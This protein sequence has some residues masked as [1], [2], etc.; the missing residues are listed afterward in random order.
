MADID[1]IIAGG[2]GASSRAD[3]SSIGGLADA[4]YKGRDEAAK[5]SQRD[6]FKD[7]VPTTPDGQPDFAAMGKAL[8]QTGAFDQGVQASNLDIARQGIQQNRE[9]AQFAATGQPGGAP[10]A[11]IVSPPSLNRSAPVAVAPALA[12][13]GNGPQQDGPPP[14]APQG[15]VGT[16]AQ[17]LAAQGIPNDQIG[18]A[19]A[20]IARQIGLSDP[21]AQINFQDPQIRNVVAPAIMQLKRM[22]LGQVQGQPPQGAP[23]QQPQQVA[24]QAPGVPQQQ[25]PQAQQPQAQPPQ[26]PQAPNP[27]ANAQAAGLI[28]P[29]V[30]PNR[31]VAGLKYRAAYL[32]KGPAQE[33]IQSQ[34]NAIDKASELTAT[35]RDFNASQA[36]PAIDERA[37]QQKADEAHA[38]GVAQSDIKEQDG[39]ISAGSMARQRLA[40]LNTISNIIDTDKNMTLG[41]GAE[42]ALKVKKAL[43]NIGW[44]VGDLSGPQAISKLNGLLASESAKGVSAR[45]AQFEFKTFLTNNPGLDLDKAGNQ[46]VIGIFSQLAKRDVDLG[47]LARQSRD[48]WQNW[49][50]VV[51]NY[52]KKFPIKDPVTGRPI[53]TDSIVAP[54]P[55]KTTTAQAAPT[56][57][58][59]KAD[60]DKLPSGAKF[61]GLDGKPWQKP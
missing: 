32:P 49:D 53:T 10:Q 30:D 5:N 14:Q 45:P 41:F 15:S 57:I 9:G 33:L 60:Y 8:F 20:S 61:T 18:P 28:P 31:F 50:N 25:P 38:T 7:G 42:T 47:K 21:N 26:Q 12:K 54:G 46:R 16:L 35:Q 1:Q 44:N 6:L 34:V 17:A 58:S 55:A 2:A 3:F 11:P 51:D 29:G 52:D 23:Q 43:E 39:I 4:Y 56:T 19:S 36:N 13:N 40:T 59:S 24:Q 22:G 48:D 27:F 37:A